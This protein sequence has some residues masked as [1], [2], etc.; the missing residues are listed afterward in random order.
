MWK[1]IELSKE[2]QMYITIVLEGKRRNEVPLIMVL[3]DYGIYA[4]QYLYLEESAIL[5]KTLKKMNTYLMEFYIQHL[6]TC[7]LRN[8]IERI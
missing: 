1:I 2:S 6:L 3:Y 4:I 5:F 8:M 7:I